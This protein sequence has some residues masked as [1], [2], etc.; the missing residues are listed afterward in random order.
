[1][2]LPVLHLLILFII[3][4]LSVFTVNVYD[5]TDGYFVTLFFR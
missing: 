4:N 2:G 1:M 5:E 3:F